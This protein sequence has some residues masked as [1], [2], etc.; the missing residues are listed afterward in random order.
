MVPW[1]SNFRSGLLT[2]HAR[3]LHTHIDLVTQAVCW[4]MKLRNGLLFN[5]SSS[6]EKEFFKPSICICFKIGIKQLHVLGYENH[7]ITWWLENPGQVIESVCLKETVWKY[8]WHQSKKGHMRR[9]QWY[10]QKVY[11]IS[12]W[13][14]A[15]GTSA[16]F[17]DKL[18]KGSWV[19]AVTVRW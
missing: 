18:T 3:C 16:I 11:G 19:Q 12:K 6:L 7:T 1:D 17:K 5:F 2:F 15:R 4:T 10:S 8:I 9:H 14:P 13:V